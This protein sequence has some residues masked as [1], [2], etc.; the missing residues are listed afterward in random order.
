MVDRFCTMFNG[1]PAHVIADAVK[2][3]PRSDEVSSHEKQIEL[4]HSSVYI[5]L[6]SVVCT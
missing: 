5:I 6:Y 2:R 3:D 4:S 1:S